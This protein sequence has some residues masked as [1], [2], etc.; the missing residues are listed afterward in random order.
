MATEN[1][2]ASNRPRPIL[3]VGLLLAILAYLAIRIFSGGPPPAT[4]SSKPPQRLAPGSA[5]N[6]QVKP[7]D[8]D[9]RIESLNQKAA[10]LGDGDRNP[11]RFQPKAPPPPPPD[12]YK[13]PPTTPTTPV[14][15]TPQ[16]PLPPP[17]PR[18]G[19][20]VK[21]IGVLETSK[22]KIGAFS[23]WDI[24]ARECRG[25]PSPG[26]EGDVLEG[27]FR[28]VRIGLE[29]AVLEY[30]DG[31]GRETLALNGQACVSK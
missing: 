29:S 20:T 2:Q 13:P 17:L 24:Q 18:I 15:T 7:E 30:L 8:L 9:V 28:I 1:A 23:F 10:P 11:F 22:G 4:V 3:L 25:V 12:A 31:R 19:E 6:G 5:A 16:P 14:V 21:F 26:K 27:R